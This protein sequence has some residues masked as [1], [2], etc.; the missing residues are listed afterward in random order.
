MADL[1]NRTVIS[2]RGPSGEE[3]GTAVFSRYGWYKA[4]PTS[5]SK[6]LKVQDLPRH[7]PDAKPGFRYGVPT[8]TKEYP[9]G[10]D[11]KTEPF[12]VD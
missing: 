7:L 10:Y 9:M 3:F 6:H 12:I 11:E 5:R 2:A 1:L 8:H 4:E